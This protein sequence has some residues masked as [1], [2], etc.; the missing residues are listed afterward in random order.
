M[1]IM[2]RP[3]T[4]S[5]EPIGW[6][7]VFGFRHGNDAFFARVRSAQLASLNRFVPFNVTLMLINVVVL[8][9]TLRTLADFTFLMRWG[10]VMG[11]LALLWSARF[12]R[13][14][15]RGIADAVPPTQFWLITAEV[16]GFGLCWAVMVLHLM[17]QAGIGAQ[18]LLMLMSLAAMGAAGLSAVVMPVCGIGMVLAIGAA[19]LASVPGGSILS[20]PMIALAFLTFALVI[21]R[22]IMVS[23]MALM[24]RMRSEDGLAERNEMVRL[25]LSEFESNGSDWLIEV[26]ADGRL[27]HVSPRLAEVAARP[28]GE[29]IGR[30]LLDLLGDERRGKGRSSVKALAGAFVARRGFRDITIPVAVKGET[31]W[32][33]LS[34]TPKTDAL[35]GFA[36]YRGVGRDVT[37]ARRSHDRIVEL[38]RYDPLTGLANRAQFREALGE[39]LARAT[40]TGRGC[41]LLFIDLDH[42]KTINDTLGHAAGDR[43]LREAGLRMQA[44]VGGHATLA[45]LGGDEFAVLLPDASQ[46]RVQGV[47]AAIIAAMAKPFAIDGQPAR[48]GASIGYAIGPDDGATLDKLLKSADLAL[49]EAKSHGRGTACRY[50]PELR[51]RAEER[52]TMEADLGLALE[53]GELAL[54]FQPVV[55]A[56]DERITGFEA[57]LRW[58]NPRLGN[59]PPSRFIPI[60]E[61]TG[62]I[63]PIGRWVIATA[64]AWAARWPDHVRIAVNLSP[65]QIGDPTLVAVVERALAENCLDPARLELEITESLFLDEKPTTIET[66]AALRAL[67]VSFALD[68]F[69]TGYSSLGYLHKAAFSRI[70]IDRS[71]VSRAAEANGEASAIIQAIV[72]LAHS[73]DMTT[74]A[75]GTE[76]RAEF[77][78]C[79]D[80]GCEQIQG[81]FFGRPMP[82]EEATA[83]VVE[84]RVKAVA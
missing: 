22:G 12:W 6:A 16:I 47:A 8:L 60:A 81:Y 44:A 70:K 66:L 27:T 24:V 39:N 23:S 32:W 57:L 75:E 1:S 43:L 65:A 13:V 25:L 34:G 64:C 30:P 80:L 53:R 42:F 31:R 62:M 55:D 7:Q 3:P 21:A 17:P 58:H 76:T 74:T 4:A 63:V 54:A 72:N 83:L 82:P 29:L 50:V 77:E 73:L 2:F 26:D 68:D 19:T 18:A 59:I 49:Y 79:R 11:G 28:Q 51:E 84:T 61:D 78:L 48:I 71:F 46:R 41:G 5:I 14:K 37:E 33:A 52:R 36:G 56:A 10:A 67:G 9:Y 45:R 35:G 15:Q 69:G 38:A 20:A 40:R